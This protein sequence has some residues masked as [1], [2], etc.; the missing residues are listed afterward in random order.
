[1]GSARKVQEHLN[2]SHTNLEEIQKMK[3]IRNKSGD[4][5]IRASK[6]DPYAFGASIIGRAS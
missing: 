2:N 5:K 4:H 6:K 3:R 1:V